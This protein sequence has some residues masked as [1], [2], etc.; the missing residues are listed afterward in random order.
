[1]SE[2]KNIYW[3]LA[4]ILLIIAP[5]VIL[6]T[7][8]FVSITLSD[9]RYKIVFIPLSTSMAM[10]TLAFALV[11]VWLCFMYFSK[12]LLINSATGIAAIVGFIFI[13]SLGVQNYVYLHQDYIEYNPLWGS[14]EEYK[15]EELT[16][17]KHEMFDEETNRDEKYIFEFS[18]GYKFEFLVSGLVDGSVKSEIYNKLK[19]LDVPYKE[20]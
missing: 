10:Y 13:F 7:P 14:K 15:W 9:I 16:S 12:S 1:M 5:I 6:F 4:L 18:D 19:Q 8:M 11:I 20:Y 2:R 3:I 17:V